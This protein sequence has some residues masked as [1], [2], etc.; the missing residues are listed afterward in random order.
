MLP[1]GGVYTNATDMAHYLMFHINQGRVDGRPLLRD[2]LMK[3]MHTV[4][5]PNRTRRSDTVGHRCRSF[6]PEAYYSHGGGG[7]GFGS[8]MIMFPG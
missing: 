3:A 1:A 8:Y 6:R 2:D 7:Y 4:A 5:F